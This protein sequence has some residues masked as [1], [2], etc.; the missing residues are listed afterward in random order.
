MTAKFRLDEAGNILIAYQ[1]ANAL[2]TIDY[3]DL[4]GAE[5]SF[6]Q[7]VKPKTLLGMT[8]DEIKAFVREKLEVKRETGVHSEVAATLAPLTGFD[9]DEEEG[10]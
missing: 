1:G 4:M 3:T 8:V 9:F 5:K 2:V 7:P 10:Q 6:N